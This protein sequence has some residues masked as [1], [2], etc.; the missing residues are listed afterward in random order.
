V[1]TIAP[2]GNEQKDDPVQVHLD[3][4]NQSQTGG[5]FSY[6]IADGVHSFSGSV[7]SSIGFVGRVDETLT[8]ALHGSAKVGAT[9]TA[10][11]INS[12]GAGY[13]DATL[14]PVTFTPDA[15]GP[16][17]ISEG[18]PL[19]LDASKTS[20]PEG[21]PLT[22]SWDIN[23][24]GNWVNGV[25]AGQTAT[26]DT[27][28]LQNLDINAAG[29]PYQVR[30]EATDPG[31]GTNVISP[32]V[33]LTVAPGGQ[34]KAA[35]LTWDPKEGGVNATYEVLKANLPGPAGVDVYWAD[36]QGH[37]LRDVIT[38]APAQSKVGTYHFHLN[39]NTVGAPPHGATQLILKADPM[40]HFTETN[41]GDLLFALPYNPT[42]TVS[43]DTYHSSEG[44]RRL[45]PVLL[46]R[47]N[48]QR[49]IYY[50]SVE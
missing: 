1:W 18:Q 8:I 49:A 46:R 17:S 14:T 22:Y 29:S 12:E 39:A 3:I 9:N 23:V 41:P 38:N 21:L 35:S 27:T 26:L 45:W 37:N 44:G 48:P 25:A 7:S 40:G 4:V 36:A 28:Q 47:D 33:D 10:T 13:V 19:K 50:H 5:T 11:D 34:I 16:Y 32:T 20:N 2:D 15:G 6:S 31:S 43:D 30:V 42:V 24:K